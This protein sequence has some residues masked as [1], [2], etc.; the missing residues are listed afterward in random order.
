MA[1]AL[2]CLRASEEYFLFSK[3]SVTPGGREDENWPEAASSCQAEAD[4]NFMHL[5]NP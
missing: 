4:S 5:C 1:L 3:E 2:L